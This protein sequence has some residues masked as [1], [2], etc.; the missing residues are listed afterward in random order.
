MIAQVYVSHLCFGELAFS[1]LLIIYLAQR[2][3]QQYVFDFNNEQKKSAYITKFLVLYYR[4]KP[5]QQTE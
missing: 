5:V 4:M 1:D 3:L 2:K